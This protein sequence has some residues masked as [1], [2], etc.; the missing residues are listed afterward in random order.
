MRVL[1]EKVVRGLDI[2]SET[3]DMVAGIERKELERREAAYHDGVPP[4]QVR[5][6]MVILVDDG[7]AT[8]TNMRAAVTWLRKQSPIGILV[9]VPVG[10]PETCE[11]LG[12]EVDGIV[13]LISPDPFFSVGAWYEDFPQTTDQEVRQLLREACGKMG[14]EGERT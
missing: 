14:G 6:R 10:A 2:P 8:G 11:E 5:D 1:N 4:L 13:C 3:I 7:L 12:D 9:V